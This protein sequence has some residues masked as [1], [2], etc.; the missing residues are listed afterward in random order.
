[1]LQDAS[2]TFLRI[3]LFRD[4][5]T[6]PI[7]RSLL[8]SKIWRHHVV[9]HNMGAMLLKVDGAEYRWPKVMSDKELPSRVGELRSYERGGKSSLDST[10]SF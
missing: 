4:G 1:M 6:E 9:G 2:L 10:R 7:A 3:L 8:R 5:R